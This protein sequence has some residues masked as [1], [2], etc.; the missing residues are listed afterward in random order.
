[1]IN[2][3]L[4]AARIRR[5][6]TQKFI[7]KALNLG[8]TS[9]TKRENGQLEFTASEIAKLKELLQLSSAEVEKIFFTLN[10][11]LNETFITTA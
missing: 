10:V 6:Y 4:K 7:A 8:E 1:M 2:R 5:G 9:Y 3:E 11:E